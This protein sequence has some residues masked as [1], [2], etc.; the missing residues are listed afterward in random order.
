MV[1]KITFSKRAEK[2]FD[3]LDKV[4]QSRITEYLKKVAVSENPRAFGKG[5]DGNLKGFTSYRIA[6][7]YR[8]VAKIKDKE[9]IIYI[10]SVGKRETIYDDTDI[11]LN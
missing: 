10:I 5:L 8:V 7:K 1:Y 4:I 6:D 3:K 9:L 11:R 2:Q